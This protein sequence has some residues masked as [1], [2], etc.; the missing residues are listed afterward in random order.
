MEMKVRYVLAAAGIQNENENENE[1][2]DEYGNED[3]NGK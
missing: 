1:N 3:G 2:A